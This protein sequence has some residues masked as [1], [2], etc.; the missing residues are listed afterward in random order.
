MRSVGG[1][2]VTF[3]SQTSGAQK[4][5]MSAMLTSAVVDLGISSSPGSGADDC[6]PLSDAALLGL[7]SILRDNLCFESTFAALSSCLSSC[8]ISWATSLMPLTAFFAAADAFLVVSAV[9]QMIW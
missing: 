3:K 6:A 8:L 2:A 9:L 4:V 5:A 1:S 7:G